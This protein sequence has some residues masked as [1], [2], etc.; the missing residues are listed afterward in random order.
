LV[1]PILKAAGRD[2]DLPAKDRGSVGVHELA[3]LLDM[4]PR[5]VQT[6][7]ELGVLVKLGRDKYP[8]AR[9]CRRY[10]ALLRMGGVGR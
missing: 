4:S 6:L 2:D 8:R 1:A 10:L 9:N 5:W 3:E 7:T